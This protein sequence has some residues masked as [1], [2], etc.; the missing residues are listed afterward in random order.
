MKAFSGM[1]VA[2]GSCWR[3]AKVASWVAEKIV[4]KDWVFSYLS[5]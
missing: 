5:T 1:L 4:C 3:G 2:H